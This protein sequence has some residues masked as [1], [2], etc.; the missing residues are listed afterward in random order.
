[1]M[2]KARAGDLRGACAE[3]PKWSYAGG[4]VFPGL[5]KRRIRE[6]AMCDAPKPTSPQPNRSDPMRSNLRLTSA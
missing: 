1:M 3:I 6:R 2:V 4:R 5:V